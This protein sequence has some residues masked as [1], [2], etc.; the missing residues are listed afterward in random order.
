MFSRY[1]K[2]YEVKCFLAWVLCHKRKIVRRTSSNITN[3]FATE[4]N[5]GH[6]NLGIQNSWLQRFD[7]TYCGDEM[8]SKTHNIFSPRYSYVV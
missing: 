5:Q 7:R 2:L 3:A 6:S 4:V 8:T 1:N